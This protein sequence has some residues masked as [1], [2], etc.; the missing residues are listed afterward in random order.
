[1]P[2]PVQMHARARRRDACRRGRDRPRSRPPVARRAVPAVGRSRDRA[3]RIGRAPTMRSTD[4]APTCRVRLPRI[5]WAMRTGREGAPVAARDSRRTCP[6][7]LP[8]PARAGGARP[9][10]TRTTGPCT[11]GSPVRT[12]AD[13]TRSISVEAAIAVAGFVAA[14]QRIDTARR[15]DRHG[16]N[17]RGAPLARPR[18]ADPARDRGARRS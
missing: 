10:A 16:A 14:L 6:L 1:M 3:G 5:G 12:R 4:S 9:R 15:T 13:R 11:G 18:R 2:E 8:G 7:A 17:S